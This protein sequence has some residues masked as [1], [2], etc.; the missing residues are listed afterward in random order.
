MSLRPHTLVAE[1][2]GPPDSLK[3]GL[4]LRVKVCRPKYIYLVKDEKGL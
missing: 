4:K 3:L 1:G 2:Y